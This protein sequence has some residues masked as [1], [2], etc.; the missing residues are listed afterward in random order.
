MQVTVEL[1]VS[2]LKVDSAL[3]FI[4]VV[5]SVSR[6]ESLATVNMLLLLPV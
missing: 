4:M 5:K 2:V 3:L 6:K 1:V